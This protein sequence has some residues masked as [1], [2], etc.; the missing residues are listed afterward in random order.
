M[1]RAPSEPL[2]AFAP[3]MDG[4]IRHA[5]QLFFQ[6]PY[7]NGCVLGSEDAAEITIIDLDMYGGRDLWA[8][9]RERHPG[10]PVILLSLTQTEADDALF[11]RKPIERAQFA[12]ALDRAKAMVR[13]GGGGP[14]ADTQ[15]GSGAH[16]GRDPPR[17]PKVKLAVDNI[18]SGARRA[19][20]TRPQPVHSASVHRAGAR[21]NDKM[22]AE[23]AMTFSRNRRTQGKTELTDI[24]YRPEDHLQGHIQAAVALAREKQ[25]AV[26]VEGVWR[27]I[28]ILGDRD[29]VFVEDGDKHLRP[30][31]I[32]PQR[33]RWPE[34]RRDV[35][36]TVLARD[37]FDPD[38]APGVLQPIEAFVWKLAVWTSRGRVPEGTGLNEP[39][40]LRRW[41]NMTR[42][43]ITPNALRICALWMG[44][45]MTLLSTIATLGVSRQ[46]VFVFYAAAHAIGLA[47]VGGEATQ[48][49]GPQSPDDAI[50]T[51]R[52][53]GLFQRIMNRLRA[54]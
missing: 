19:Q 41:P 31:C 36:I 40:H 22:H 53:H 34:S 35:H 9:H 2:R 4:R 45:P 38:Q 17:G 7:E 54:S 20:E 11:V 6:G 37:R 43:M 29:C 24:Y 25:A 50:R 16:Q 51:H 26:C 33:R 28:T 3:G 12:A 30:L 32:L 14:A 49:E 5:L 48:A 46:D 13:G 15:A 42:L 44:R 8:Q 47:R 27:P 23:R 18:G 39:V 10:R 52:Q 21:L 1:S